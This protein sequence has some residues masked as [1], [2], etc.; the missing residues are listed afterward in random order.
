MQQRCANRWSY[1]YYEVSG[2]NIWFGRIFH[3]VIVCFPHV[4]SQSFKKSKNRDCFERNFKFLLA[5]DQFL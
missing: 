3:D 5:I 4:V 1:Y 2:Y